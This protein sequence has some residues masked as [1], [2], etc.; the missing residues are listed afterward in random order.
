MKQKNQL[1][2]TIFWSNIILIVIV[3][4]VMTGITVHIE[5]KDTNEQIDRNI[6]EL[7]V[8]LSEEPLL[9]SAF[10]TGHVTDTTMQ[11]LDTV[12]E[13][14]GSVDYIVLADTDAVRLYHPDHTMIG[15][16][17]QG[18]DEGPALEGAEIYVTEGKGS[19][20][21]QRRCFVSIK[22][23]SGTVL[24]FIMV[25]RYSKTINELINKD[26]EKIIAIFLAAA[27]V[28]AIIAF[29]ISK[30]I[31]KQLLGYEPSQIARMFLQREE[32]LDGLTEGILLVNNEGIC[33]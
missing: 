30:R 13:E 3:L 1:V 23:D 24:G 8:V 7:A 18:G 28:S 16:H 2:T 17:F 27:I 31:R 10:K 29:V 20:E 26:I 32:V 14:D 9:R 4:L 11:F 33:E 19:R 12:I 15:K 21:H 25:S 5:K 6:R 22:D